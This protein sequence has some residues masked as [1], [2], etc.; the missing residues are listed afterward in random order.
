MS[1]GDGNRVF[2]YLEDGIT[3]RRYALATVNLFNGNEFKILEVERENRALS[4][5]ILSSTSS[6]NWN[7]LIDGLLLNL[8]NS[9]GTWEREVLESLG[10]RNIVVRKAKHSK[11]GY[12]HRARLLINKILRI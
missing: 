3:P 9:S 2:S 8:V 6:V 7:Q 4:M 11:K 10:R 1:I 5:L 12:K